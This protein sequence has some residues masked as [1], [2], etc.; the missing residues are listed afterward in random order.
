[1]KKHEPTGVGDILAKLKKTSK[2]G[3]QL[4]QAQIWEQWPE[5]VG[6]HLA[7]HGRPRAIRNDTLI[8]EA[9]SSVWMHKYA[10]RKWDI[11]KHINR[12]AGHELVSDVYVVLEGD[13]TEGPS[14]KNGGNGSG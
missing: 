3:I 6:G 1:M 10:Y 13:S 5:L 9:E 14:P 12:L 7:A 2:L 11:L 4:E 8:I